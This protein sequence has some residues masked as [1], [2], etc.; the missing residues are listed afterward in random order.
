MATQ[1]QKE[2][3]RHWERLWHWRECQ[4]EFPT[5]WLRHEPP[6]PTPGQGWFDGESNCLYIWDGVRW[7]CVPAD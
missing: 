7:I 4:E 2:S 1:L 3:D 5:V 6:E